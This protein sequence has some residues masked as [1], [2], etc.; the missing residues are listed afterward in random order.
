MIALVTYMGESILSVCDSKGLV[1]RF[2][3]SDPCIN[4]WYLY[5]KQQV[6]LT[7]IPHVMLHEREE[8]GIDADFKLPSNF[9]S[10]VTSASFWKDVR[11]A[12]DVLQPIC[13]AI[14][15]LESDRA[16][17]SLVY[18]AFVFLFVKF[19]GP[20]DDCLELSAGDAHHLRSRLLYRW[21]RICSP[22][23]ALA[24]F[25]D[26]YFLAM[27]D[28]VV[29][30]FGGDAVALGGASLR[31]QCMAALDL[32]GGGDDVLTE[33]LRSD[34]LKFCARPSEVWQ[35]LI[36]YE[37]S[38][39]WGQLVELYPSLAPKL[40][41][42]YRSPASTAG[43]ERNH[44]VAKRGI[45][46]VARNRLGARKMECQ[47]AVKHNS[48]LLERDGDA[49][50]KRIG[51]YERVIAAVASDGHESASDDEESEKADDEEDGSD[52]EE[53][54]VRLLRLLDDVEDVQDINDNALFSNHS[55]IE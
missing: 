14:G 31:T 25:C 46:T 2:V 21:G 40:I 22:V 54:D 6:V 19:S 41:S 17:L 11:A 48:Q 49:P 35:K 44:K 37:P 10:T 32:L 55:D 7:S 33:A 15:V 28:R 23:H 50:A 20:G 29:R 30:K 47:L 34:F 45:H 43:V 52:E 39:V 9:T 51:G 27:R 8:R 24:Y 42:L 53:D 1:E 5:F 38:L 3:K 13:L 4:N 26:P 16:T 18:A 36:D 12:N